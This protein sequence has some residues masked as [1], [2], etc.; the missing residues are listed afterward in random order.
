MKNQPGIPSGP[1]DEL[2]LLALLLATLLAS[3]DGTE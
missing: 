3:R 1:D 2:P